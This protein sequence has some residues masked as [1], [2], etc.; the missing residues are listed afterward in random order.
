MVTGFSRSG[1]GLLIRR[2]TAYGTAIDHGSAKCVPARPAP[3][4][5]RSTA[6][7]DTAARAART[8]DSG[9]P[10]GDAPPP[11]R[12]TADLL[13]VWTDAARH[14]RAERRPQ[15]VRVRAAAVLDLAADLP[16][17]RAQP[18]RAM[19][20][21]PVDDTVTLHR[22]MPNATGGH[23]SHRRRSA[24]PRA[25]SVRPWRRRRT[26]SSAPATSSPQPA[27]RRCTKP[28][29]RSA[30]GSPCTTR[31]PMTAARPSPSRHSRAST[32]GTPVIDHDRGLYAIPSTRRS[33]PSSKSRDLLPHF[34]GGGRRP[35]KARS[36][37]SLPRGTPGRRSGPAAGSRTGLGAGRSD[38]ADVAGK[39]RRSAPPPRVLARA[40]RAPVAA[41]GRGAHRGG[42]M[43]GLPE[44]S[45]GF[46]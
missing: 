10:A 44:R 2:R 1:K 30:S 38:H 39:R 4:S 35:G 11:S 34:G 15:G 33:T 8:H 40:V 18:R 27:A 17:H 46:W 13:E 42:G 26:R 7:R 29:E 21:G 36:V 32:E 6:R 16:L 37:T 14:P 25:T 5:G 43:D 31:E 3:G 20:T 24:P 45:I 41:V 19:N 12:R 22:D 23:R 9:A 28:R